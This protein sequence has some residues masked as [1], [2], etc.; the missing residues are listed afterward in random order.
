MRLRLYAIFPALVGAALG[1]G[2]APAPGQAPAPEPEPQV[3]EGVEPLAR[4]PVHEA[5]AQPA[6]ARVE[7]PEVV[8]KQPPDPIDEVPPDEKPE[9]ANVEWI[10]GYWDWDEDGEEFL[11][12]SG[13]WRDVPPDRAWV[14][15]HWQQVE[16][17][18]QWVRGFWAEAG[19]DELQYVPTP[20][21][22]IDN[23]PSTPAPDED[24]IYVPGCWLWQGDEF[25]WR[26]GYWVPYRSDWVW[27][28]DQY[29]WT[30]GGCLFVR[31][32]W[33]YPL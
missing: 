20:P 30:P 2:L 21:A 6:S 5:F 18:W 15:G 32:Y 25:A 22:S 9:G 31:G 23:G 17:G 4:G 26:P 19:A 14:P 29:V 13:F 10:P 3:Q 1:I 24:S 28:P 11:W 16:G 8:S 33:D 7:A 12:V 27:T